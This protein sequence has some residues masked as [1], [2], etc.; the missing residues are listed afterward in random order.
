MWQQQI[1]PRVS[2]EVSYTRR[3]WHN[4]FVTDDL[5]RDVRTAYENYTL[6]APTDSRLPQGGGYPITVYVPTAAA[7]AIPSRTYL[8]SET[9]FGPE[10]QSLWHGVGLTVNARLPGG[11]TTQMG[12][13]T[14]RSV[15]DTCETATKYNQVNAAT[16][17]SAG[18]DPRGC[19]NVEPWQT[20]IRG[21]ATYVVPKVDVLL[22]GTVRSQSPITLGLVTQSAQWIVP[23][24]LVSAA[25]GHLPV[26][27]TATGTTTIQISDNVNRIY[28]DPRRTQIDLRVAK[29]L[30]FGRTRSD[31]GI[32]LNNLL[33]TNY[34]TAYNTTYTYSVNNTLQGGTWANP[35]AIYG[36]RFVRVNFTVTF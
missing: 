35:T 22:S 4:F 3:N 25:L 2:T 8:T 26:G 13:G 9:D 10:R 24:S 15:V 36:A 27:A 6:T 12:F 1:I 14:G 20:T 18:P 17:V 5:N 16:N 29:V 30:R 19:H 31:V 32:D 34:P 7:N 11:L 33:N 28:A 23:N 21:L